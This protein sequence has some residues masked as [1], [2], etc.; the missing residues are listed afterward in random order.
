MIGCMRARD[1]FLSRP[2]GLNKKPNKRAQSSIWTKLKSFRR[3]SLKNANGKFNARNGEKKQSQSIGTGK[4]ICAV[5]IE[6]KM[7]ARVGVLCS[8]AHDFRCRAKEE[9]KA[10]K[11]WEATSRVAND[12]LAIR[13][14]IQKSWRM[15]CKVPAN[16]N[17]G[18][19]RGAAGRQETGREKKWR[20]L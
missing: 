4:W 14:N 17:C 8:E 16:W 3:R 6:H 19:I 9:K 13:E 5:A 11:N 18:M 20:I 1:F 10:T 15:I 7:C 2:N 12:Y